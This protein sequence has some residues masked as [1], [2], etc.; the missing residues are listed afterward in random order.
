MR[1]A[2]SWCG[3][4][5]AGLAFRH[6]LAISPIYTHI[7]PV[8]HLSSFPQYTE[9]VCEAG[10]GRRPWRDLCRFRAAQQGPC[11]LQ[12]N[13]DS[14]KLRFNLSG[15]AFGITSFASINH[16]HSY[17]QYRKPGANH[18]DCFAHKANGAHLEVPWGPRKICKNMRF[19]FG[20]SSLNLLLGT[21]HR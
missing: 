21:T 7:L 5:R 12:T 1:I 14:G 20:K 16:D 9:C 15:L 8:S 3:S 19:L 17:C 18:Y 4:A 10:R 13:I 11:H 6:L 2:K